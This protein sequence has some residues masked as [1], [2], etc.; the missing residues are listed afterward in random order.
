[1]KK[2]LRIHNWI[3]NFFHGAGSKTQET[4]IVWNP[5][6]KLRSVQVKL[7]LRKETGHLWPY[8]IYMTVFQ[9]VGIY[10]HRW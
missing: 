1:M 7:I 3:R 10:S 6:H 8:Y 5:Q 2:P 4:K 9:A